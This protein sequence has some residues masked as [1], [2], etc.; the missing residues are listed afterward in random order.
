MNEQAVPLGN[1]ANESA[2]T[3]SAQTYLFFKIGREMYA[4]KLTDIR[5]VIEPQPIKQVPNTIPSFLGI[6]NLR[7]Q[8]VGILDLRIHFG[9]NQIQ[10]HGIHMIFDS[11]V[12]AFGAVIDSIVGVESVKD[13]DI[14][15]DTSVEAI[16]PQKYIKG[17]A[18]HRNQLVIIVDV[19]S[20]LTRE[21]LA[22]ISHSKMMARA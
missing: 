6:C 14:E 12:G 3:D 8:I 16:V 9:I 11:D 7:G 18:K 17:V 5:E 4:I 19:K 10:S 1:N 13:A 15:K 20:I 22:Q 21:E 2:L